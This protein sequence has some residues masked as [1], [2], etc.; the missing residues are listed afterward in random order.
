LKA[1]EPKQTEV[2]YPVNG[3]KF[4]IEERCGEFWAWRIGIYENARKMPRLIA[5]SVTFEEA[6]R[7]T[8]KAHRRSEAACLF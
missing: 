8:E 5:V 2:C 6:K 1:G 4:V 3:W 7:E